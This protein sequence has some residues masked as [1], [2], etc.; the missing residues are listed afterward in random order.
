VVCHIWQHGRVCLTSIANDYREII[1]VTRE[2]YAD[3]WF[4]NICDHK[5]PGSNLAVDSKE[6]SFILWFF[7]F[8]VFIRCTFFFL[9]LNLLLP[10]SIIFIF[11]NRSF[12]W[13]VYRLSFSWVLFV[14]D[15]KR[16]VNGRSKLG[17]GFFVSFVHFVFLYFTSCAAAEKSCV[18]LYRILSVLVPC[19]GN[20]NLTSAPRPED[21]I[22]CYSFRDRR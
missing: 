6:Y 13:P 15:S 1:K 14:C 9:N 2:I 22:S 10:S 3:N 11:I 17:V 20:W 16:F 5:S 4:G 7:F 19:F 21:A 8:K 12:F 18:T